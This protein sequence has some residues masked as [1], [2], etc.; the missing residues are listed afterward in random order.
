MPYS[1]SL[2]RMVPNLLD[3]LLVA[4]YL[5]PTLFGLIL[6]LP[7]GKSIGD[8]LAGRFEIMGTERG[9]ITAGLQI[10]TFFGFAVSAQTFWISSKISEGGDFCS[11]SAVFNCDDLIGNNDLNVD[12][13][14]GLSWGMIGMMVNAFL[15]FMVLV[16]KNEPDGEYTERFIKLGT[17]ITG[18]GI[19]VVLLLVSYEIQEGK[20]CLYCT[21]AHIANIAALIGF[22]RLGKL[23]DDKS[24]W[25]A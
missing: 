19:F 7:F 24:A 20:I 8:K 25:K 3:N 13:V 6:V 17:I 5:L 2:R 11:S 21:T 12:P 14:F 23:F 1:A 4:A 16:I 22:F 9:R 10:I 15:L 18:L